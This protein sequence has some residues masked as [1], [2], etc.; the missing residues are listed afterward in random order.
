MVILGGLPGAGKTSIARELATCLPAIH[1]RID[2]IEQVIADTS[3]IG[4][5]G[6]RVA[7]ALALD[8]L[9]LGLSVIADSVNPIAI[10]RD[11]WR[12]VAKEAGV[13][14][15]E[16]EIVCSDAGMHRARVEGRTADIAGHGLPSWQKVLDRQYEPWPGVR[17]IDTGRQSP[18]DAAAEILSVL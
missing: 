18:K 5:I 9:R 2:T 14:A 13:K 1:L 11:A 4:E 12:A 7:Y 8:N 15:A 17:R 6:Y 16:F 10:T 3:D